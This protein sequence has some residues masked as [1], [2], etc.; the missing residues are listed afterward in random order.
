VNKQ[1]LHHSSHASSG[2]ASVS[3]APHRMIGKDF[4][5]LL[6][7]Y[8]YTRWRQILW[9]GFLT[10]ALGALVG[11]TIKIISLTLNV[12]LAHTAGFN[13]YSIFVLSCIFIVFLLRGLTEYMH[14]LYA[15]KFLNQIKFALQKHFYRHV[16]Q[17]DYHFFQT[18]TQGDLV[19]RFTND[20]QI[21]TTILSNF[22]LRA[23]KDF[24]TIF[25][26]IAVLF[27]N[28]PLF[29]SIVCFIFP[30]SAYIIMKSGKKLHK[31]A[32]NTQE[33]QGHFTRIVMETFQGIRYIKASVIEDKI[34]RRVL[35]SIEQILHLNTQAVKR[36]NIPRALTEMFIGIAMVALLSV[37]LWA[38]QQTPGSIEASHLLEYIIIFAFSYE[39]L[40]RLAH[41]QADI[42]SAQ[43]ASERFYHILDTKPRIADQI[44]AIETIETQ[45]TMPEDSRDPKDTKEQYLLTFDQAH[46]HFQANDHQTEVNTAEQ[47][48]TAMQKNKEKTDWAFGPLD[49]HIHQG[50]KIAIIGE[51]GSGKTTFLNLL[52]RFFDPYTGDILYK[53]QSIKHYSVSQWR[54]FLSLVSQDIFLFHGSIRDNLCFGLDQEPAEK[55]YQNAL[56]IAVIDDFIAQ[57]DNGDQ[58]II[59]D[60][61]SNISGGQKQRLSLVRALLQNRPILLLDEATSALDHTTE[62]RL[63]DRLFDYATKHEKTM[64]TVTHRLERLKD[65][66]R[67]LV[68]QNGKIIEMGHLSDL[69]AKKGYLY[70][71]MNPTAS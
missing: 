19:S 21:I 1:T 3:S 29:A 71:L 20:I 57:L 34:I 45:S 53:N 32:Q 31:I 9:L 63:W 67:I 26:L 61:A 51:S 64:I 46:F 6:H 16:M 39:P 56:H 62:S 33:K 10:L 37:F 50:E 60:G 49:L 24:A 13:H 28:N 69:L 68:M 30:L 18:A 36:K 2:P 70:R 4:Q 44:A 41:L 35:G 66:D 38:N 58:T 12:L 8:L 15:I 43:A 42:Q 25:A 59:G 52:M 27:Y 5:R 23:S 47:I 55:D 22:V 17:M 40:K 54:R 65:M 7:D 11:G 48:N 14:Q